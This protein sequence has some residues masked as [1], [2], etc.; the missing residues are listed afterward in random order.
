MDWKRKMAETRLFV[1]DAI[2]KIIE[3]DWGKEF[4]VLRWSLILI[5]QRI[6]ESYR[7]KAEA[8]VIAD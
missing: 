1:C 8:R 5:F 2:V 7:A 3:V 6:N 4:A